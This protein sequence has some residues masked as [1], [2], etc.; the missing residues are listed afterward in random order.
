MASIL[1]ADHDDTNR[2]LMH[3]VLET[4]GGHHV[5]AASS[6]A[7]ARQLL[8]SGEPDLLV[9]DVTMPGLHGFDLCRAVRRRGT[10]PILVVSGKSSTLDRIA[11]LR[12]GADDY[13][14]KPF[15]PTEFLERANA[16]LRR[17]RRVQVDQAG[18][19]IRAGQLR[20]RPIERQ[21]WVS[22][23]GPISL[24]S[25]ESRLLYTLIGRPGAVWSRDTLLKRLWDLDA[26]YAGPATA[27][28]TYV[29][30]LRSKMEGVP[31]R[32]VY[33][34]TVRGHGYQLRPNGA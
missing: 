21:L 19:V 5:M 24:T 17:A 15:D 8:D 28:E 23:R 1:I 2:A 26:G 7:A 27:V 18:A 12:S 29:A 11:G 32:P 33:L 31:R 4:D 30:R 9:Y 20:L 6:A 34:V 3:A 22:D 13:L 14:P 25:T 10:L 16:L